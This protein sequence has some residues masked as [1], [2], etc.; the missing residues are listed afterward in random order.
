LVKIV[1]RKIICRWKFKCKKPNKVEVFL[2]ELNDVPVRVP[3]VVLVE[4]PGFPV[5]FQVAEV[6][7]V[8]TYQCVLFEFCLN[9]YVEFYLPTVS[10]IG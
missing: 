7:K 1:S 4:F 5:Q 8:P 2:Y 3:Q 6:D 9:G 10:H